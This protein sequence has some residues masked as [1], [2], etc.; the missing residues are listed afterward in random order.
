LAALTKEAANLAV[1]R[2]FHQ[3]ASTTPPATTTVSPTEA[4]ENSTTEPLQ[5]QPQTGADFMHIDGA[6]SNEFQEKEKQQGENEERDKE[7]EKE[8][9][10]VQ[11]QDEEGNNKMETPADKR[12]R[13][14][15]R[16]QRTR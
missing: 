14:L 9:D 2:I 3:L 4:G 15:M 8:G 1:H 6:P 12:K 10:D 11:I 7:K 16:R 13:Q 5:L